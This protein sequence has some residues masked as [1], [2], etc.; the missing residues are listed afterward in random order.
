MPMMPDPIIIATALTRTAPFRP[1]LSM[2]TLANM[3]PRRPPTVYTDVTTENVASD[4]GIQVG[5]P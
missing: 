4:I 1:Q 5:R 2:M 3:L